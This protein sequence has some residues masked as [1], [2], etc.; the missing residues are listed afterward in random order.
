MQV[1][2]AALRQGLPL[3][4]SRG[5]TRLHEGRRKVFWM[6]ETTSLTL[7]LYGPK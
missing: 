3:P 1:L 6:V 4:M 2:M 7:P 5:N